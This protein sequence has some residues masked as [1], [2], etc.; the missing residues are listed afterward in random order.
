VQVSYCLSDVCCSISGS[1]PRRHIT[2]PTLFMWTLVAAMTFSTKHAFQ[3]AMVSKFPTLLDISCFPSL[4]IPPLQ[5]A[6]VQF[7]ASPLTFTFLERR[8]DCLLFK[9]RAYSLIEGL[10]LWGYVFLP[11][12]KPLVRDF[13]GLT[14]FTTPLRDILPL[15]HPFFL[16][17]L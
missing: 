5:S 2:Q 1:T 14:S 7:A 10:R 4:F 8:I 16:L 6:A 13:C 11:P 12:V 3:A 9:L 15:I 17:L